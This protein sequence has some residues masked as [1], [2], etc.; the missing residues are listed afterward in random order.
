[1]LCNTYRKPSTIKQFKAFQ[2]CKH[3]KYLVYKWPILKIFCTHPCIFAFILEYIY[4][5]NVCKERTILISCHVIKAFY[6][7]KLRIPISSYYRRHYILRMLFLSCAWNFVI[8]RIFTSSHSQTSG[9]CQNHKV[10][11]MMFSM[12]NTNSLT[13]RKNIILTSSWLNSIRFLFSKI[14]SY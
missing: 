14:S 7:I 4:C 5:Y 3:P 10:T 11:K 2:V 8:F 6:D 9:T 12:D 13:Q 1:M